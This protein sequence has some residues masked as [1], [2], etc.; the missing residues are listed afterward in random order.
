MPARC[1]AKLI[2]AVRSESSDGAL[3][4][5]NPGDNPVCAL[6]YDEKVSCVSVVW[7]K[8]ATSVQL[9]FIHEAILQMMEKY[10]ARKI[11]G[12]DR[13]LPVVHPEDQRWIIEDWLPR[14]RAAG[15]KRVAAIAS[16]SFFGRLSI[17]SI[18]L[19]LAN[20]IP[21]RQFHSTREAAGWLSC[22]A[23]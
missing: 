7:R 5:E 22:V 6:T 1:L 23:D 12:D 20:D 10:G 8:Y 14:A 9:R 13:E 2:Q 3:L 15:L 11:L 21:I 4:L 17:G 16:H 18:Q 19:K